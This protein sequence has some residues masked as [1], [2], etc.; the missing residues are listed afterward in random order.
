MTLLH[1]GVKVQ[2]EHKVLKKWVEREFGYDAQLPERIELTEEQGVKLL[3]ELL[4][5]E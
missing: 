2:V 3:A 1:G 4:V 5:S